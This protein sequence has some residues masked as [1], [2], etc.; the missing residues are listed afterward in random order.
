M[1][2]LVKF[3]AKSW[4]HHSKSSGYHQIVPLLGTQL[5]SLDITTIKSTLIPGRIAVWLAQRSGVRP[6]NYI[7]FYNEWAAVRDMYKNPKPTIYHVIYGDESYRYLGRM[8]FNKKHK[9]VA[10]FHQPPDYLRQSV[11][12]FEYLNGLDAVIVVG[13]NQK[14]FLSTYARS[15]KIFFVPHGVNTEVFLPLNSTNEKN[16]TTVLFVGTHKRDFQTLKKVCE[17]L[18]VK[19]SSI[20]FKVVT[21]PENFGF[22]TGLPNVSL[23]SGL[24]EAELV[25]LYQTSDLFVQTLED[26]TANNAVLEA[27]ACG[28][29]V[30]VTDVGSIRDYVNDKCGLFAPQQDSNAM[31]DMI[32]NLLQN[33]LRRH[34]MSVYARQQALKFDWKVVSKQLKAVYQHI[35]S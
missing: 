22:F 14:T 17:T 1:D 7:D 33:G 28:L 15:E 18:L 3:I 9:V 2:Y 4:P 16:G 10:S 21:L 25:N 12:G 26:C 11:R 29:P 27:L 6:Y 31:V 8:R 19:D 20:I 30:V 23:Y 35:L 13:S 24:T 32:I 34:E 5:A